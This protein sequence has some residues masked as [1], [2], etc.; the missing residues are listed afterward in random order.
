V[1]EK[2]EERE[3]E[4]WRNRESF[5]TLIFFSVSLFCDFS[6]FLFNK[7]VLLLIGNYGNLAMTENLGHFRGLIVCLSPVIMVAA[8]AQD[9]DCLHAFNMV[10]GWEDD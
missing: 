6:G 2:S 10:P 1:F 5:W 8:D 3:M 7:T 9:K 4:K